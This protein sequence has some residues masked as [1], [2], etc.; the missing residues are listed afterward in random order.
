MKKFTLFIVL[1]FMSQVILLS[2]PCF[3]SGITFTN[4][5][6]IDSFT[7]NHPNCTEIGGDLIIDGVDIYNLNGLSVITQVDGDLVVFECHTLSS[8]EGLNNITYVGGLNFFDGIAL[9]N[10]LGLEGLTEIGGDVSFS[11][12]QS[13]AN[14]N[15]LNNLTSIGG[16]VLIFANDNLSSFIG[17]ESLTSIGD[18]LS[19]G[20]Y[21]WPQG[22]IGNLS[23]TSLTGLEY[24]TSVSG[25]LKIY[26]NQSLTSLSGIENIIPASIGNLAIKDNYTLSE[27][28]IESICGYLADPAGSVT[29]NSNASGCDNATQIT[30]A[31]EIT[32]ISNPNSE[33]EFSIYPNPAEKILFIA[34]KNDIIINEVSIYNQIGQIVLIENQIVNKIDISILQPGSYIIVLTSNELII[35][36]KLI[37]K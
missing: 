35:R 20:F 24:L 18:G 32:D 25:D 19:I 16:S 10:L 36:N 17:L 5:T 33:T 37:V 15:G 2:Q 4:Q 34:S 6:D 8:L 23:L 21:G 1:T 13:L 7:T 12:N 9:T 29:V 30:D 26:G 11:Y 22:T 27:C 31:C 14:F 3:P 28:E